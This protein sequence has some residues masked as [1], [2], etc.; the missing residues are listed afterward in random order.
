MVTSWLC[1]KEQQL[2][3]RCAGCKLGFTALQTHRAPAW[4]CCMQR[5]P[6]GEKALEGCNCIA[7]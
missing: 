7:L 2:L 6:A 4:G 1:S 5:A 3:R